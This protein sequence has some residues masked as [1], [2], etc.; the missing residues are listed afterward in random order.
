MN[1]FRRLAGCLRTEACSIQVKTLLET[2]QSPC[3]YRETFMP[4]KSC[5]GSTVYSENYV[6]VSSTQQNAEEQNNQFNVQTNARENETRE[7]NE[8]TVVHVKFKK[9]HETP[10]LQFHQNAHSEKHLVFIEHG[11][12]ENRLIDDHSLFTGK[13]TPYI[14]P[15]TW[16]WNGSVLVPLPAEVCSVMA[17]SCLAGS[18]RSARLSIENTTHRRKHMVAKCRFSIAGTRIWLFVRLCLANIQEECHYLGSR[19]LRSTH[20]EEHRKRNPGAKRSGLE[21]ET[22][23]QWT[24]LSVWRTQRTGVWF[25]GG[26]VKARKTQKRRPVQEETNENGHREFC[27]SIGVSET[28]R[29]KFFHHAWCS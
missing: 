19:C 18:Y 5:W 6:W 11:F 15:W 23:V 2:N 17:R 4:M 8:I 13:R 27:C 24:E 21:A 28:M 22:K 25:Y 1:L 12:T 3:P 10:L 14:C 16:K 26:G 20:S 9:Q 29:R 7:R